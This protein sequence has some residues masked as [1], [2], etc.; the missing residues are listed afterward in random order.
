[1][2]D[3]FQT[4]SRPTELLADLCTW[5][6]VPWSQSCWGAANDGAMP[7][8]RTTRQASRSPQ[9]P[10]SF[11]PLWLST[12]STWMLHSSYAARPVLT[13]CCRAQ[14]LARSTESIPVERTISAI[15]TAISARHMLRILKVLRH[16][17][18]RRRLATGVTT[19]VH[20]RLTLAVNLARSRMPSTAEKTAVSSL[21]M[22]ETV[23][24][25]PEI[26]CAAHSAL[27]PIA[28]AAAFSLSVA[29]MTGMHARTSV[30]RRCAL[31]L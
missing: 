27:C 22:R 3:G 4:I 20:Q 29:C 21:S 13:A 30:V 6:W 11:R 15:P 26:I 25:A 16:K 31:C 1:M 18:A 24:A 23:T 9:R 7:G 12:C 2:I 10:A 8:W 28:L 5:C 17:Y 19:S 14:L